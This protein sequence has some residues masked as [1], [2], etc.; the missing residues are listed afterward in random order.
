MPHRNV[1]R[2]FVKD[3]SYH[4][5]NRGVEQRTIFLDSQDYYVFLRRLEIMLID[6]SQIDEKSLPRQ[7]VKSFYGQIELLAYCLMP[8]HFH[9]L[10]HQNSDN[11]VAEFMRTLSTSYTMYFNKRY[12]RVGA[13]FQ[14]R[15][16]AHR[17]DNDSYRLHI[18]R[19]IHLNPIA[20]K[21]DVES[22]EYSSLRHFS[23]RDLSWITYDKVLDDFLSYD[24][25][26][27]FVLDYAEPE[28]LQQL[29]YAY[30]IT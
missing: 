9:L 18:S 6:R 25:Y 21:R 14:G 24:D 27:K 22:F 4:V 5:Y 12:E 10:L 17:I 20:L 28:K 16:K 1:I 19:Y 8:N 3:T 11:D 13:L 7:P 29:E 26:L 23:L 2:E 30:D 15:Y